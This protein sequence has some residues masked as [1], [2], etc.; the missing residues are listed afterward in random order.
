MCFLLSP[1]LR[2]PTPL[3][4]VDPINI[5]GTLAA[6][7]NKDVT[8]E[9]FNPCL[10][11]CTLILPNFQGIG[12]PF[13]HQQNYLILGEIAGNPPFSLQFGRI[14]TVNQS[15]AISG[16]IAGSS[17]QE[18]SVSDKYGCIGGRGMKLA[19]RLQSK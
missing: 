18:S 19:V 1:V 8:R 2:R 9:S 4:D 17:T 10:R 14:W 11:L 6:P 15:F 5:F 16:E 7:S 3:R 13:Y 12:K